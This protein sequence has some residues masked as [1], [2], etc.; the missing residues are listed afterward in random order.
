MR[1]A[2]LYK[3]F[4]EKPSKNTNITYTTKRLL[5]QNHE[6]FELNSTWQNFYETSYFLGKEHQ[7]QFTILI[8]NDDNEPLQFES[9]QAYQLNSHL[10]AEL[11]P[12][13]SYYLY[14][15]NSLLEKPTYD[16][17][18]F[19]NE[20]SDTIQQ[21][22]IE[23]IQ[24]KASKNEDEFSNTNDKLFV[25]LGLI[26]VGIILFILTTQMIKKINFQEQ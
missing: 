25:W 8:D 7:T 10:I 26:I 9:I 19:E 3:E 5:E 21:I 13:I 22:G 4:H 12:G 6:T 17:V 2:T 1:K 20:I 24:P 18:Y 11:Q 23:K 16:L 15:G 14:F